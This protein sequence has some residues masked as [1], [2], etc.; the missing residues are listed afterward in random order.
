[1][2][3]F[4]PSGMNGDSMRKFDTH[5]IG[6]DQGEAVLFEA[7]EDD[8]EMWAGEGPR[9]HRTPVVFAEGFAA[10]PAVTVGLAMWDMSNGSN[11]RADVRAENVTPTGFD[12]AFRTWGDTRVARVRVSWQAIGPVNDDEAWDI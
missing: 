6:V 11:M 2:G 1:M 9:L 8:G 12:I 5:R 7:F 10:Q 4:G 3:P